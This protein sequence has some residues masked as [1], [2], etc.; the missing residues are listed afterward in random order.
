MTLSFIIP[1]IIMNSIIS[2]NLYTLTHGQ[3]SGYYTLFIIDLFYFTRVQIEI[4]F[5]LL[6]KSF[7]GYDGFI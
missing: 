7:N 5:I 2:N 1:Q 4:P 6:H 3:I